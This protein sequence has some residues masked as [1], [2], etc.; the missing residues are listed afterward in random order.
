M[1]TTSISTSAIA[2]ATR[3]SMARLQ[4]QLVD[5]QKEVSTG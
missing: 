5:A 1:K 4:S 3:L 2:E